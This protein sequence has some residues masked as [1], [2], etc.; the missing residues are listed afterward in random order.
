MGSA[1]SITAAVGSVLA[2]G[3]LIAGWD[4]SWGTMAEPGPGVYPLMAGLL[5]LAGAVGLGLE[6]RLRRFRL[7]AP[8]PSGAGRWR[9][10]AVLASGLGYALLLPYLG[11]PF[12]GTIV[13]LIVLRVM[14]LP[15]WPL[16]IGFAIAV[17]LGSYYLFAI[18]L[19][20]P[21]PV[22][23]WFDKETWV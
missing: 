19:D 8:W 18:I 2:I 23:I 10:L 4:Y 9:V 6:A 16:C 22:G 5:M 3:Y 12:A 13:S 11:H 20:V 1:Y 15:R 21:L 17:G 14:G 7:D